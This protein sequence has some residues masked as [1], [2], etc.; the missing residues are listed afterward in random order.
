MS[1]EAM[2]VKQWVQVN[3][4]DAWASEVLPSLCRTPATM[5]IAIDDT[6]GGLSGFC[7]WDSTA[8]GF[9]GPVGI[10]EN[11][12]EKGVGRALVMAVYRAMREQGYGYA[13]VGDAGPA[14]FFRKISRMFEIENS[15]PGIYPGKLT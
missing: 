3:F 15:R 7:A 2:T 9:L 1:S 4:N 13:V 6:S 11:C 12:R 8:L 10:G 5:F 14:E